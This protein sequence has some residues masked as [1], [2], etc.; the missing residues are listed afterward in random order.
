MVKKKTCLLKTSLLFLVICLV[1]VTFASCASETEK[2]WESAEKLFEENRRSMGYMIEL[3][4]E[5]SSNV[6]ENFS[7]S[8]TYLYATSSEVYY[9]VRSDNFYD[10]YSYSIIGK[11]SSK[12]CSIP[13]I[14]DS[15]GFVMLT[16]DLYF[17][18]VEEKVYDSII[19]QNIDLPSS[20]NYNWYR[21][22][23][24]DNSREPYTTFKSREPKTFQERE[25]MIASVRNSL[26][27]VTVGGTEDNLI[28]KSPLL[29]E[30]NSMKVDN[31]KLTLERICGFNSETRSCIFVFNYRVSSEWGLF[32]AEH[33]SKKLCFAM[34]SSGKTYYLGDYKNIVPSGKDDVEIIPIN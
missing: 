4:G 32:G 34:D 11:S 26:I 29:S 23:V 12:V 1:C 15:F 8:G 28:A 3:N 20:Y 27:K 18:C 25:E 31:D 30:L 24:N 16:P 7:T 17:C 5:F 10:V 21:C 33:Y 2:R 6:Y 14:K 9:Y 13:I 19:E 22:S